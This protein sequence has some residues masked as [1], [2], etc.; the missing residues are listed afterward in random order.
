MFHFF[1]ALHGDSS[2]KGSGLVEGSDIVLEIILSLFGQLGAVW[3]GS[4]G[5]GQRVGGRSAMYG[6]VI[7]WREVEASGGQGQVRPP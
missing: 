2:S 4:Q 7:G 3:P 5:H 1:V 6:E